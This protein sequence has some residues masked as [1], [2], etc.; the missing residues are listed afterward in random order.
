MKTKLL[1]ALLVLI[2]VI[3]LFPSAALAAAP[4]VDTDQD[5]YTA[6]S[7]VNVS[8]SSGIDLMI[9]VFRGS[10]S[11]GV[12]LISSA[13]VNRSYSFKTGAN[14]TPGS[15]TVVVGAGSNTASCTFTLLASG[16]ETPSAQYVYLSVY[17]PDSALLS[18]KQ[19]AYS[20]GMSAYTIL[21]NYSGL[22][23]DAEWSHSYDTQ[24]VSSIAGFYEGQYGGKSGWMYSVNGSVPQKGASNYTLS[25]GDSVLW[26]YTSDGSTAMFSPVSGETPARQTVTADGTGVAFLTTDKLS[27][28]AASG[29]GFTVDAEAVDIALTADG[30]RALSEKL[31]ATDTMK[32]ELTKA[33]PAKSKFAV[34]SSKNTVAALDISI[35]AGTTEIKS[36]FGTMTV[37]IALGPAYKNKA[38]SVL[39]LKEDSSCEILLATADASGLL[40]FDTAS[41]STFVVMPT[42]NIP[43]E[44]LY[45]DVTAGAW[46]VKYLQYVRE[47]GLMTGGTDKTF[48]PGATLSRAALVTVLYR[49][50]GSPASAGESDFTDVGDSSAWYH[51]AVLWAAKNGI[52]S[53]YGSGSFAPNDAVTREQLV[54]VFYR[55]AKYSGF[56]LSAASKTDLSPYKDAAQIGSWANAAFK[57]AVG[58]GLITGTGAD[59]LSPSVSGTRCELAA[60]IMRFNEKFAA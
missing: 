42:E 6:G 36:G 32:I 55:Y 24:Y 7:T 40:S 44:Y 57:W 48:E 22:D 51:G 29:K 23:V 19:I 56:D 3:S 59:T 16:G 25:A 18:G 50:A 30:A 5:Y 47:K 27:S 39:H 12:K 13:T 14:W 45:S 31:G 54:T 33:A 43:V 53:G 52:M 46:Y 38:L 35:T 21:T 15:Y 41:L 34:V 1:S 9:E 26:F 20:S 37:S 11:D 4:S 58:T 60:L 8:Q 49:I 10:A 17:G 2:L 28:L